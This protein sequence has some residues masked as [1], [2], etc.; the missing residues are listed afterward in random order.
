MSTKLTLA[1]N[2]YILYPILMSLSIG[3]VG[4]PNVGK[5]TLFNALT[6]NNVLAANYP[7]ATIEPNT[8]IVPVP[9]GRLKVLGQMFNSQKIIPATVTFIDIAG[10]V[11]GAHKGEGMGNAFL[12]HIRETDAIAQVVRAFEDDNVQHVHDKLD[13]KSDID[14]INT[15]LILADLQTVETHLPKLTKQAKGDPKMKPALDALHALKAE[16]GGEKLAINTSVNLN[17]LKHLSL[18]TAKPFIYV[19]NI[20]EESIQ[21]E[22]KKRKLTSLA[23]T[24][25]VVFVSA[26]IEAELSELDDSDSKELMSEY[27]LNESGLE[28]LSAISYKTLGLQSY[29]TAGEKESRAWTIKQGSTAP[30]AAGVIH[31]DF[32]KGFIMADIVSYDDLVNTGSWNDA[33]TAG[34]LRMEGKDYTMQDG[35]VVEF[36]FSN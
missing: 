7:F 4:L 20:D 22:E 3:I 21:N 27:G 29:L 14:T 19:F 18:L 17:L 26:K 6:K 28:R 25:N 35:D 36:K 16:L 32:E 30:Q 11:Q 24:D 2:L 33:K 13:P 31:G 9:D 34:K 23:P 15:E 10:I 5:S 12:S 1:S 8:G